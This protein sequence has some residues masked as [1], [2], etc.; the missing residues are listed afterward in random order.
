MM[1]SAS[2]P[3]RYESQQANHKHN[4]GSLLV[5]L[6]RHFSSHSIATSSPTHTYEKFGHSSLD[7]RSSTRKSSFGGGGTIRGSKNSSNKTPSS[8]STI[9]NNNGF[10][11]S[12]SN[13]DIRA[14]SQQ[15]QQ[16]VNLSSLSVPICGI[17]NHGNTCFMNAIL[18]CL[19]NTDL[20]AEY[21]VMGHFRTDL[22]HRTK[23]HAKKYGTRGEVTDQLALLLKALWSNQYSTDISCKFKQL[24][25]KYGVQYEGSDQHDAQEFLL[26]L[27]DKVHEDLNTA[28]KKKYKKH[29]VS[30]A[31]AC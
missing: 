3:R 19:S 10:S 20:F 8:S 9:Y 24:V 2:L 28:L 17:K 22:M 21:F 6:I 14:N 25:S 29:K 4:N 1:S 31:I 5:R 11:S 18:Q 27:L 23:L 26:W 30:L 16:L 13:G 15:N 12:V 7:R